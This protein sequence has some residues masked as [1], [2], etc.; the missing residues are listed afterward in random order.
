MSEN[1]KRAEL[2]FNRIMNQNKPPEPRLS[3]SNNNRNSL[4]NNY[5]HSNGQN[6]NNSQHHR[7]SHKLYKNYN[8]NGHSNP[9]AVMP[10]YDLPKRDPV[11]EADDA[12]A[13][14][15][16]EQH[17]LPYCWTIWYHL[18]SKNRAIGGSED[19][20]QVSA[21]TP[22][23]NAA[24]A[25]AAVDSYLQTTNEIAFPKF[26]SDDEVTK[27]I[28]SLEQ[29]WRSM[30]LMKKLHDL[31]NGSEL[32]VFKTGVNPVWEDPINAR[33]GRWVF[34][35]N[36]RHNV[37]SAQELAKEVQDHIKQARRRTTLIWERLLLRTLGGSLVHEKS[38]ARGKE[39]LGDI[40]GLVLSVRRDEDIISVWNSNTNFKRTVDD[41]DKKR[42][43]PFLARRM[44]CEAVLRVVRECDVILQGSDCIETLTKSTERVSGVTFEYRLHQDTQTTHGLKDRGRRLQQHHHHKDDEKTD[45]KYEKDEN[46][47]V[48]EDLLS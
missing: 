24:K 28:A 39:M 35:F 10:N 5:H 34:R 15:I 33:G 43:T 8:H 23:E 16:G 36:H 29:L 41:D 37:N 38:A 30:L 14:L 32:L 17:V 7:H 3:T 9:P 21:S 48:S 19:A 22:G 45:E 31:H 47:K 27:S 20:S 6:L 25:V 13:A 44:I 1:L 40:A 46:E 4:F 18:R 12:V 11:K 42:M 26:G 2:L